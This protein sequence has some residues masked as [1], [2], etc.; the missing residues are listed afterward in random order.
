MNKYTMLLSEFENLA[1]TLSK[2]EL[3]KVSEEI[4]YELDKVAMVVN[5][6]RGGDVK[7]SKDILKY[8]PAQHR[9]FDPETNTIASSFIK[10]PNLAQRVLR[11]KPEVTGRGQVLYTSE[12]DMVQIAQNKGIPTD[13]QQANLKSLNLYMEHKPVLFGRKRHNKLVENPVSLGMVSSTAPNPMLDLYLLNTYI[14]KVANNDLYEDFFKLA[15]NLNKQAQNTENPEPSFMRETVLPLGGALAGYKLGKIP[16][17]ALATFG[18]KIPIVGAA[19]LAG[20][21]A[22][23]IGGFVGTKHVLTKGNEDPLQK[24]AYINPAEFMQNLRSQN[25]SSNPGNVGT[26]KMPAGNISGD[27][28][29]PQVAQGAPSPPQLQQPQLQAQQSEPKRK[30]NPSS[31]KVT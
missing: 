30:S 12:D 23:G 13:A 24:S 6:E 1:G 19:A 15:S 17:R 18:G 10:K 9:H 5:S 16:G 25:R 27:V 21:A 22:G 31:P 3:D 29:S 20:R 4:L 8:K 11:R 14:K 2:E 26:N 28:N 7:F